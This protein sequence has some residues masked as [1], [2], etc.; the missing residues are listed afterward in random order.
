MQRGASGAPAVHAVAA[1][2][3]L[4]RWTRPQGDNRER[5]NVGEV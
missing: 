4:C 1:D 2:G 3:V 5:L